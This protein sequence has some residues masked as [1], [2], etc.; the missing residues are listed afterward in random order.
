MKQHRDIVGVTIGIG[1]PHEHLA[2]LAA[3]CFARYT[4]I[5]TVILGETELADSQMP[6][7]AALKFRL[8]DCVNADRLVYFDADWLC[9]GKWDPK[10]MCHTTEVAACRDF[11]LAE[12]WPGQRYE[13]DSK[14]FLDEPEDLPFEDT[15]N[16]VR[17][18]YICEI[19]DFAD[20]LLPCSRWIN[21]GLMI[22]NRQSHA[23]WLDSSLELYLGA[24]GHHAF[25]YEQPALVKA[26]EVLDIPIRLLPRRFNVLAA[27][28]TQWHRAVIGLHIKAKRHHR[29]ITGVTAGII[30]TPEQVAAYFTYEKPPINQR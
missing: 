11:I 4:G 29:F 10:A 30:S 13:F 25:Y 19:R 12:E 23:K 24:V 27:F 18:D 3:S 9:L 5:P 22:L 21:T 17:T 26:L 6:H 20:I 2:P 8:F 15:D 1:Y 16:A 28:D 7:P 14:S